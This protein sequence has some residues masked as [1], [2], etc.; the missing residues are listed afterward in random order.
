M[1]LSSVFALVALLAGG[2]GAPSGAPAPQPQGTAGV[3]SVAALES[4][5][6]SAAVAAQSFAAEHEGQ[7]PSTIADLAAE[8]FQSSP[9]TLV[10]VTPGL[11]G[12]CVSVSAQGSAD[13][14]RWDSLSSQTSA[15][16]Q[17]GSGACA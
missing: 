11:D 3:A 12:V 5:I 15:P 10:S 6:R 2:C 16:G 14:Y 4:D 9:G 7:W 1:R 8:G 17:S 13:A